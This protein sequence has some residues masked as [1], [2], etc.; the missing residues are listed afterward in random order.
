[1]DDN[2]LNT[3]L[4]LYGLLALSAH[5]QAEVAAIDREYQVK[6]DYLYN[7]SKF[8][9][10]PNQTDKADKQSPLTLCIH[11]NNPFGKYLDDKVSKDPGGISINVAYLLDAVEA[12]M[13]HCHLVF[14]TLP[15]IK[16][17]P[18]PVVENY[19]PVLLVGENDAFLEQGGHI[20]LV[21]SNGSV[22]VHI[23]LSAV[24]TQGFTVSGNLLELA[25]IVE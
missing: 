17:L 2:A 14:T 22:K 11:G 9:S 13:E 3:R 20:S 21:Y 10:W 1:M 23:N 7:L 5:T 8:I 18:I 25:K 16:P 15:T 4:M 12:K 6:A 19:S 24:Q